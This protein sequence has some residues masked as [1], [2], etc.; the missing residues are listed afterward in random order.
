MSCNPPP[1]KFCNNFPNLRRLLLI[2]LPRITSCQS[3]SLTLVGTCAGL[4]DTVLSYVR[5]VLYI[6]E[7]FSQTGRATRAKS[8]HI[9]PQDRQVGEGVSSKEN[10]ELV[11]NLHAFCYDVKYFCWICEILS[12][13]PQWSLGPSTQQQ[14]LTILQPSRVNCRNS[15]RPS[16][17]NSRST[18]S[19]QRFCSVIPL[20]LVLIC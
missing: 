9:L 11:K 10:R 20:K 16:F 19:L 8:K 1:S 2:F 18:A 14:L 4:T 7:Y 12:R 13:K 3:G 15:T 5:K 17:G 6:F